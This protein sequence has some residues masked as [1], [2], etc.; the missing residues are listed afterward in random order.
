M[1]HKVHR[2]YEQVCSPENVCRAGYNTIRGKRKRH[3]VQRMF[4]IGYIK[5]LD[6]VWKL[7]LIH[8]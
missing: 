4:R 8:I 2:I 5:T 6:D 1:A 7:S 3:D